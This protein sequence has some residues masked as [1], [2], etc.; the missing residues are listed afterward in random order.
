MQSLLYSIS[1]RVLPVMNQSCMELLHTDLEK[2]VDV[3]VGKVLL[4]L[5]IWINH[6]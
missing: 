4:T 3:L 5:S 6:L 1:I 2:R